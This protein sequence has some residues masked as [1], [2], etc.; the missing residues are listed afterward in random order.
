[1]RVVPL[2]PA[3]GNCP[4][5][6]RKINTLPLRLN[7]LRLAQHSQHQQFDR[8]S[9]RRSRGDMLQIVIEESDFFRF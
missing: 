4:D 5:S 8:Q 7:Q 3:G 9:D 1:M 2:H 6:I